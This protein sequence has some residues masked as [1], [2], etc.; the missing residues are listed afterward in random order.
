MIPGRGSLGKADETKSLLRM[1]M[2]LGVGSGALRIRS[3]KALLVV[4][5][6]SR[7]IPSERPTANILTKPPSNVKTNVVHR[8]FYHF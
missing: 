8:A 7:C 2:E 1:P 3:P 5:T 6:M 4:S